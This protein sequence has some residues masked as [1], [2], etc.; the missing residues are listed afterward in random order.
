MSKWLLLLLTYSSLHIISVGLMV[1]YNTCPE[2][3]TVL[4]SRRMWIL[5]C[6]LTIPVIKDECRRLGQFQPILWKEFFFL[7]YTLFLLAIIFM[8]LVNYGFAIYWKGIKITKRASKLTP[9]SHNVK[10][11]FQPMYLAT[12]SNISNNIQSSGCLQL[13]Y[14]FNGFQIWHGFTWEYLRIRDL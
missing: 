9:V 11:H 13:N 5:S 7:N 12:P 6:E 10:S 8:V 4:T 1:K 2:Y 14:G 3:V